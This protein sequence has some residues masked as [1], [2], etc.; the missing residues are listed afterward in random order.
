MSAIAL[1]RRITRL[2][3]GVDHKRRA[4]SKLTDAELHA[5]IRTRFAEIDPALADRYSP[6]FSV[7]E[8]H[9]IFDEASAILERRSTGG[10]P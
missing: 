5:H 3:H 10:R 7:A 6:D 9:A 2:D 8:L 4:L 1:R